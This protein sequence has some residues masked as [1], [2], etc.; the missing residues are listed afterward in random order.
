MPVCFCRPIANAI[1]NLTIFSGINSPA[2]T[3]RNFATG[4]LI[5]TVRA[6]TRRFVGNFFSL[7]IET[8]RGK[9]SISKFYSPR[10]R[11]FYLRLSNLSR[12]TSIT[13][14]MCVFIREEKYRKFFFLFFFF[15]QVWNKYLLRSNR[16]EIRRKANGMI[17]HSSRFDCLFADFNFFFQRVNLSKF[18]RNYRHTLRID[19]A[20][21]YTR[22]I[23]V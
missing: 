22:H 18:H 9:N 4:D 17:C 12:Q 5:A 23:F 13:V 21:R 3:R 20:L 2:R 6:A 11:K 10:V 14:C 19:L 16:F 1:K 7:N 8:W 15:S